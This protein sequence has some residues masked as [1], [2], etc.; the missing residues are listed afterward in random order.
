MAPRVAT[1]T[2][3]QWP[4]RFVRKRLDGLLDTPRSGA[5]RTIHDARV[6]AIV[7]RTLEYEPSGATHWSTT[8]MAR[9]MGMTWYTVLRIWHALALQSHRR[10]TLKLPTSPLFIAPQTAPSEMNERNGSQELR[11]QRPWFSM[12]GSGRSTSRSR[13]TM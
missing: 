7:S 11:L 10:E 8:W 9:E 13:W 5:S 4:G 3:A 6:E 1:H 2:V 12:G